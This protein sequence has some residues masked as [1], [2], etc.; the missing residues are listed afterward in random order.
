MAQ[1]VP[2]DIFWRTKLWHFIPIATQPDQWC[3]TLSKPVGLLALRTTSL[4]SNNNIWRS[5]IA[6]FWCACSICALFGPGNLDF[7]W[8]L[9]GAVG[10]YLITTSASFYRQ[11][12]LFYIFLF[13][14]AASSQIIGLFVDHHTLTPSTCHYLVHIYLRLAVLSPINSVQHS[15]PVAEHAA[16]D[17]Q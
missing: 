13:F 17:Q 3:L 14:Y 9:S 16:S 7:G 8:W 6:L 5:P 2:D 1:P 4:T 15:C 11:T 12:V 10:S